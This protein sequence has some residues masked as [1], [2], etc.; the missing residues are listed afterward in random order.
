MAKHMVQ[1]QYLHFRI[2]EICHWIESPIWVLK[3]ELPVEFH[4]TSGVITEAP[5]AGV[6]L[7]TR[8]VWKVQPPDALQPPPG[9]YGE[10]S[11]GFIEQSNILQQ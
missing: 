4:V 9:G 8:R 1:V 2:L 5:P 6:Q 11:L 10:M 3:H 7:A